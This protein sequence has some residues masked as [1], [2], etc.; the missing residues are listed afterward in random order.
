MPGWVCITPS[1]SGPA[2]PFPASAPRSLSSALTPQP[3]CRHFLPT[4]S[5]YDCQEEILA[6]DFD[7]YL[8]SPQG[9]EP[10]LTEMEGKCLLPSRGSTGCLEWETGGDCRGQW[11]WLGGSIAFNSSSSSS[12]TPPNADGSGRRQ[13]GIYRAEHTKGGGKAFG[14]GGLFK[15]ALSRRFLPVHLGWLCLF[16]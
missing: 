7:N 12:S 5:S 1:S 10:P 4:F 14:A 11:Q 16:W 3:R 2:E 13:N 9:A 6:G 8:P 15:I